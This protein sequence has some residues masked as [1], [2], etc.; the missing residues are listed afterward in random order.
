M[1]LYSIIISCDWVLR[2]IIF[3]GKKVYWSDNS[4][5]FE[6]VAYICVFR[7]RIDHRLMKTAI[8]IAV[9]SKSITSVLYNIPKEPIVFNVS[10]FHCYILIFMRHIYLD[11]YPVIKDPTASIIF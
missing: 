8:S 6:N 4:Q 3:I 10:R 2:N 1:K 9:R 11:I 5:P 7:I